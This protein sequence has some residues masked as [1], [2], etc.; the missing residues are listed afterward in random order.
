[1]CAIVRYDWGVWVAKGNKSG[2]GTAN[3]GFE[4]KLWLGADKLRG[5]MDASEYKHIILGLIFLK[6]ISDKFVERQEWL[7]HETKTPGSEYH[8]MN[9]S[10]QGGLHCI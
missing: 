9:L 7:F 4:E 3:I 10:L 2:K 8:T 6:Y 1:M 5:S